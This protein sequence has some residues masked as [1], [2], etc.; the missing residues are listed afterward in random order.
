LEEP[1]SANLL[2]LRRES[3]AL[4]IGKPKSLSVQLRAQGSVFLLELFDHILLVSIHPTSEDQHQ[5]LQR[6]S[7]HQPKFRPA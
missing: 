4:L 5:E 2:G 3:S 6:Q 1:S 7:V